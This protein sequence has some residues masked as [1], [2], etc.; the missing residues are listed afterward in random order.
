MPILIEVMEMEMGFSYSYSLVRNSLRARSNMSVLDQNLRK[1]IMTRIKTTLHYTIIHV[2]LP[3]ILLEALFPIQE[4]H[5][6]FLT[7]KN[8]K[9]EQD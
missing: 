1:Q 3:V 5:L 7:N 4:C 2:T 9:I 6:E 8:T